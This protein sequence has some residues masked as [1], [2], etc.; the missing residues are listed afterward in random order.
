MKI[1][2][3]N[4]P[5]TSFSARWVVETPKE[6]KNTEVYDS[7]TRKKYNAEHRWKK[8]I[9]YCKK[10]LISN[11]IIPDDKIHILPEIKINTTDN[12]SKYGD[13]ILML[14]DSDKRMYDMEY[15]IIED[16]DILDYTTTDKGKGL[17]FQVEDLKSNF[18]KTAKRI[19]QKPDINHYEDDV[20]PTEK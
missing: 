1:N 15:N 9:Q 11:G 4:E 14:S 18:K 2:K 13:D 5:K 8:I 10:V 3:I 16:K 12:T 17:Y 20:F 6:I 7:I 19:F